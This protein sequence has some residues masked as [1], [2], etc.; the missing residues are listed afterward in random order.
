MTFPRSL[1]GQTILHRKRGGWSLLEV[2]VALG[3]F[4]IIVVTLLQ[5]VLGIVRLHKEASDTATVQQSLRAAMELILTVTKGATSVTSAG[6]GT[7]AVSGSSV[8]GTV[9]VS[10]SGSILIMQQQG[11]AAFPITPNTIHVLSFSATNRT[12]TTP[13]KTVK[14]SI[15]ATD[16]AISPA[17]QPTTVTGVISLR[18]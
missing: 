14:I 3:I 12:G 15:Q 11:Q 17:R 1:R 9:N 18:P 13:I 4:C 6:N 2:V 7:L 5:L 8:F 10:M 16:P